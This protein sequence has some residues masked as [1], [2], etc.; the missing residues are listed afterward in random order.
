ML[1]AAGKF[2]AQTAGVLQF[3]ANKITISQALVIDD[4][5]DFSTGN[6]DFDG[7]VQ[8]RRG[9]RDKFRIRATGKVEVQGLIEAAHIETG[10]DFEAATGMAA[11][12]TGR[13]Q[14]GGSLTAKY[15]ECVHGTVKKI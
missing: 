10:G 1:T 4:Y 14:I 12:E 11:K 15:L 9:V 5:V 2:I 8:V 3:R 13:V 7:D 6:I